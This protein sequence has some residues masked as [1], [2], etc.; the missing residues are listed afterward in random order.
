MGI[1]EITHIICPMKIDQSGDTG[2]TAIFRRIGQGGIADSRWDDELCRVRGA[3]L[4]L[5]K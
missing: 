3:E 5:K 4:Q 2:F 1:P